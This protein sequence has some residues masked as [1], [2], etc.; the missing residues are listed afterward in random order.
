MRRVTLACTIALPLLTAGCGGDL[1]NLISPTV[2]ATYVT[3]TFT[4]TVAK[5][6]ATSHPFT[7][8]YSAGGDI[9]ATLNSVNPDGAA[10]VGMS[11]G[12]W[13]GSACQAIISN[14]RA[15]ASVAI[16]GRATAA[17]ALCVRIYDVGAL[18]ESQDYEVQ[19][20]H[21]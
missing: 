6:G 12:T 3:D 17:G 9:T 2:P 4:G 19:V 10:V 11:L 18:N 1:A 20:L 14:D 8:S 15:T 13:N 16:V 7:V 21:P 5:N